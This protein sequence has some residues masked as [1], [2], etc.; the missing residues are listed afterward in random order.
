[1]SHNTNVKVPLESKPLQK[2]TLDDIKATI[3]GGLS[4]F[5]VV[6]G[7]YVYYQPAPN[8]AGEHCYLNS[9]GLPTVAA[10]S[11]GFS[12]NGIT[13]RKYELKTCSKHRLDLINTP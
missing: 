5:G 3:K 13:L 8:N 9:C 2:D 11:I 4:P 7:N 6:T 12:V 10:H 1:M